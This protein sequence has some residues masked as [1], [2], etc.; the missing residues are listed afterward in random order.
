MESWEHSSAI[1]QVFTFSDADTNEDYKLTE[2]EACPHFFA[3][4][5]SVCDMIWNTGNDIAD[6]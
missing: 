5:P 3:D 4:Y 6:E 2:E 1:D